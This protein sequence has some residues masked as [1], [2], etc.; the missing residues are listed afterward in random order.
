MRADTTA[1]LLAML[2]TA[3]GGT[4]L[5][6]AQQAIELRY[7][8]AVGRTLR[9]LAWHDVALTIGDLPEPGATLS[10]DTL[11]IDVEMLQSI[12][13]RVAE[14]GGGFVIE[15]WIDSTTGRV[16]EMSGAW[17]DLRADPA[18]L[19]A[20]RVE[21]TD[22][23][24]VEAFTVTR[25]ETGSAAA[26]WLR[27]PAGTFELV[28]PEAPVS[29]GGSW[30]TELVMPL[31]TGE[32]ELDEVGAELT[33]GAELVARVDVTLDSVVARGTDTLAYLRLRGRF[34]PL[35]VSEAA[36]VAEGRASIRGAIAGNLIWSTG[37][38]AWVSGAARSRFTVRVEVTGAEA[39]PAAGF[40]MQVVSDTRFQVRP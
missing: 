30:T 11:R 18:S 28:F 9:T 36:E 31:P 12:S 17:N 32:Q 29:V 19:P 22:R 14:A 2:G 38:D 40:Q 24:Q 21:L 25:G 1:L 7:G 37:W 8:P 13:E 15:R 3:V 5:L 27:N 33:E 39:I 23:L 20:A 6:E 10:A 35:T 16:R 26:Q 4:P 34:L